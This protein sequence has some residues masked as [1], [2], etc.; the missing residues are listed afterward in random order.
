VS[1]AV[2]TASADSV[3]AYVAHGYQTSQCANLVAANEPPLAWYK[4]SPLEG[5]QSGP[6]NN[7]LHTT[8]AYLRC[9]CGVCERWCFCQCI[10]LVLACNGTG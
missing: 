3:I 8:Q 1:L 5:Y 7:R 2:S 4:I 10:V 9:A 6:N